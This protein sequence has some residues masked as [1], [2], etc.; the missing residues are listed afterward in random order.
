MGVTVPTVGSVEDEV[1]TEDE[2]GPE[3]AGVGGGVGGGTGDWE[4]EVEVEVSGG[5]G[6]GGCAYDE[7][8]WAG[9]GAELFCRLCNTCPWLSAALTATTCRREIKANVENFMTK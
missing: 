5:G 1:V 9:G 8:V 7:V 4:V 3:A 2:V 6:G